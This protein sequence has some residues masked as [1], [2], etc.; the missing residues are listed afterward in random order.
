M[1]LK[2]A[3][4]VARSWQDGT[5]IM[6]AKTRREVNLD[7]CLPIELPRHAID[8]PHCRL[9]LMCKAIPAREA[10]VMKKFVNAPLVV[11]LA[12]IGHAVPVAAGPCEDA[13]SSYNRASAFEQ[14]R[15]LAEQ[16]HIDAQ[17]NVGCMYAVGWGV[18]QDN[19]EAVKW[20]RRAAEQGFGPAQFG[21][22]V[23]Y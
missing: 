3:K 18:T 19:F 16:G 20:F 7:H 5:M 8:P 22:G 11:F 21:L 6:P 4:S 14:F 13:L 1:A 10:I 23:G 12:L 2:Q 17:Y 9:L 15:P